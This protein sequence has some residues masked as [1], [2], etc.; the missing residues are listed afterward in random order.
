[1]TNAIVRHLF[2]EKLKVGETTDQIRCI[3]VAFKTICTRMKVLK[4]HY[5]STELL[6]TNDV[7]IKKFN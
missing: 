3:A 1:M 2:L 5:A 4:K 6:L 7:M